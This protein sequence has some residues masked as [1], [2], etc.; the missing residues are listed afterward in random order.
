MPDW[1]MWN[2]M[3]W[4]RIGGEWR[5]SGMVDETARQHAP[6]SEAPPVAGLVLGVFAAS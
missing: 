2:G 3:R 1:S 5:G 6:H 4:F